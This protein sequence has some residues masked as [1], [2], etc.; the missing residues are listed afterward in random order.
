VVVVVGGGGSS[1]T[2]KQV[3]KVSRLIGEVVLTTGSLYFVCVIRRSQEVTYSPTI[4]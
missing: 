4:T 1:D 3:G 2:V